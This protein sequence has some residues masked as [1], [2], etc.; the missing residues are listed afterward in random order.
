M[1]D[2]NTRKKGKT[3]RYR[4]KERERKRERNKDRQTDRIITS[5]TNKRT[6]RGRYTAKGCPFPILQYD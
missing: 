4:E 2:K 6:G 3:D 5:Q 1:E